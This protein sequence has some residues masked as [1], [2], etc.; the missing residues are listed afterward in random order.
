MD[1]SDQ[2]CLITSFR[3]QGRIHP[4]SPGLQLV[5]L[6]AG[7]RDWSLNWDVCHDPKIKCFKR[8][9]EQVY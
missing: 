7:E 4:S 3:Q 2:S 9:A 5:G 6:S 1:R 8:E